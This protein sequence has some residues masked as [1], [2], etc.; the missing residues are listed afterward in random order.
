MLEPGALTSGL[1][2]FD[3]VGSS[4]GTRFCWRAVVALTSLATSLL[5]SLA[6]FPNPLPSFLAPIVR[7]V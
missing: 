5:H 3:P 2:S 4:P 1:I 7:R 6:P